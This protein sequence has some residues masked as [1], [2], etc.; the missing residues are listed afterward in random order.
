MDAVQI[1]HLLAKVD[2]DL[3]LDGIGNDNLM[4]A[5]E[6]VIS[7]VQ[8]LLRDTSSV[9]VQP[10]DGSCAIQQRVVQ[11]Q[12]A[13]S[14][15]KSELYDYQYLLTCV[16][17]HGPILRVWASQRHECFKLMACMFADTIR[18]HGSCP[19]YGCY[20]CACKYAHFKPTT[21]SCVRF[22]FCYWRSWIRVNFIECEVNLLIYFFTNPVC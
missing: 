18:I 5:W 21:P 19:D 11:S 9:A 22:V 2:Y 10:H 8:R 1:R 13:T 4:C 20:D 6:N 15:K 12:S 7:I 14:K 16:C 17:D 3:P